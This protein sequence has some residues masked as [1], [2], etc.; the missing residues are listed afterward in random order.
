MT[1]QQKRLTFI[2]I[3]LPIVLFLAWF[4]FLCFSPV[5]PHPDS[6]SYQLDA[7]HFMDP[8]WG[9][10]RPPLFPLFLH[11]TDILGIK[12]S[13]AAFLVNVASLVCFV[14]VAGYRQPLF[15]RR[16]SLLLTGFFLLPALWSFSGAK[17]TESVIPAVEAWIVIL[18]I[19]L[20]FPRGEVSVGRM[21]LYAL[22]AC[23]LSILLKPWIMFFTV[24]S[25]CLLL[26]AGV[27]FRSVRSVRLPSLILLL[28]AGLSYAQTFKYSMSKSPMSGN[29]VLLLCSDPGRS[30]ELRARAGMQAD[31]GSE[32]ATMFRTAA[33]DIDLTNNKYHGDPFQVPPAEMQLLR[34]TDPNYNDRIKQAFMKVYFS[35][36][37]DMWGLAK[38]GLMRY[39]GS[40]GLGWS[41]LQNAGDVYGP[42]RPW[43]KW[44]SLISV[45]LLITAGVFYVIEW[46]RENAVRPADPRS[47][48][49]ALCLFLS[50]VLFALFLCLTGG[51]E[52]ARTVMPAIFLQVLAGAFYFISR[53]PEPAAVASPKPAGAASPDG[54]L[55][56]E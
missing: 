38:L 23:V 30:A 43:F 53:F 48:I 55:A 22:G 50:G 41:C 18:L 11:L 17:L 39:I 52:L 56:T 33:A 24:V 54:R 40:I 51:M 35:R 3:I 29:M 6:L 20:Y 49:F 25:A 34:F 10:M 12:L 4:L 27:L 19:K 26:V 32:T 44:A 28:V 36:I 9:G 15:S 31:T 8:N 5:A 7:D 37:G 16:N 2:P 13:L 45:L 21:V 46:R 47:G 42:N 1:K 14:L